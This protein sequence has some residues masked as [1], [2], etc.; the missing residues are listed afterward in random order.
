MCV[1]DLTVCFKNE[2]DQNLGTELYCRL[3]PTLHISHIF[4]FVEQLGIF[5]FVLKREALL[6]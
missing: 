1:W 4:Q 5:D 2:S 6:L 3:L